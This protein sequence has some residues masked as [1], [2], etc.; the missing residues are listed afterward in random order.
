MDPQASATASALSRLLVA[1]DTWHSQFAFE[2]NDMSLSQLKS[3]DA[4]LRV[5]HQ[6]G[7]MYLA[8]P[9][10]DLETAWDSFSS[11][12]EMILGLCESYVSGSK[13]LA[14]NHQRRNID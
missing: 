13:R 5:R 4:V 10:S 6:I 14:W 1:L 7:K 3:N 2:S 8:I 9:P 11:E 12:F